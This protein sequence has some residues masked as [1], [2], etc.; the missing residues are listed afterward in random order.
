VVN[1]HAAQ[2]EVPSRSRIPVRRDDHIVGGLNVLKASVEAGVRKFIF[3]STGGALR[4]AP[5]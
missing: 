2:A 1:H 5:T 4:G 3:I